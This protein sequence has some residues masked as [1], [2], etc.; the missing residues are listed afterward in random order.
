[1]DVHITPY[2]TIQ[3]IDINPV[4]TVD[5]SPVVAECQLSP[6]AQLPAACT[7][8]QDANHATS[9]QDR[10]PGY[11]SSH[12]RESLGI[13]AADAD[14]VSGGVAAGAV[15]AHGNAYEA[16]TLP[17]IMVQVNPTGT[18]YW[19]Q[20]TGQWEAVPLVVVEGELPA[21]EQCAD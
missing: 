20:F 3:L 15:A 13:L 17:D 12:I 10:H 14:S 19:P 18:V 6:P 5:K 9:G 16:S 1:M 11:T 21:A 7:C 2:G 8:L 4:A